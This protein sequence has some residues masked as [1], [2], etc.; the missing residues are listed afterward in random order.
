MSGNCLSDSVCV[1]F[2]SRQDP[3]C[4][5]DEDCPDGTCQDGDCVHGECS[6]EK[7]CQ[8]ADLLCNL[9]EN[10]L[11]D[12]G[13]GEERAGEGRGWGGG[14]G[15]GDEGSGWEEMGS[16]REGRGGEGSGRDTSER[17]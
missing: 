2:S 5:R 14:E 17:R 3:N 6:E 1:T 4:C 16:G 7:P 12:G 13:R 11:E 9:G 8:G 10:G 15:K